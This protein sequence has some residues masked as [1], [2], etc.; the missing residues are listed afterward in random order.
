VTGNLGD[1]LESKLKRAAGVK[2]SGAILP[3]HGGM[4]DRLDSL[5]F[6]APWA[7]LTLILFDYVS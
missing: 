2:D 7:Y 5:L 6:S 4:L 3:G 1:L